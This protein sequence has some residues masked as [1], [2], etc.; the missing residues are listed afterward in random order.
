MKQ[1]VYIWY[2]KIRESFSNT[3]PTTNN[4]FFSKSGIQFKF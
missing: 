3:T 4:E 1:A 2:N